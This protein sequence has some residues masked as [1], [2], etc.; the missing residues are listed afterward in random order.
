VKIGTRDVINALA[1][2]LGISASAK[3]RLLAIDDGSGGGPS[4]IIR[5]G[6][7]DTAIPSSNLGTEEFTAVDSTKTSNNGAISGQRVSI[8][9]FV[10]STSSLSFD[11]QGYT[12][13]TVSNHG[14]GRNLLNDAPPVSLSSKV[15]GEANGG[16]PVN[17][18]I[19]ASGRRVETTQ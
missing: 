10:L 5:D 12:T 3:A 16:D 1:T 18:T 11:V 17:G 19:S 9:H 4:F 8:D 2:D 7:T 6:A 13:Q 15:N 14:N